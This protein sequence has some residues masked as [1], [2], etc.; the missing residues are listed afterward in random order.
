MLKEHIV[1]ETRQTPGIFSHWL[2]IRL[3]SYKKKKER[4]FHC[5]SVVMNLT[6]VHEDGGSIPGLAQGVKDP[7]WP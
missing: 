3:F 7:V 4:R 2:R 5:G 1:I 6:S